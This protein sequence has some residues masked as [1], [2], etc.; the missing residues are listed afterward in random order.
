MK[1]KRES[2]FCLFVCF[3][4]FGEFVQGTCLLLYTKGEDFERSMDILLL[5]PLR[6][7]DEEG[8]VL[9]PCLRNLK[10]KDF[11]WQATPLAQG[12]MA[13]WQCVAVMDF[14]MPVMHKYFV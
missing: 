7:E 4:A 14:L 1:R 2:A 9:D 6:L 10:V 3:K 12:K 8:L 11:G 5:V 13:W